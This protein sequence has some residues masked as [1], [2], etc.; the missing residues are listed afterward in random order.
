ME[1]DEAHSVT[2]AG[3]VI[4]K[5]YKQLPSIFCR[6]ATVDLSQLPLYITLVGRNDMLAFF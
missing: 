2:R 3:S 1:Q 6:N 5:C 4:S